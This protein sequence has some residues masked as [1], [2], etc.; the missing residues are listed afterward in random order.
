MKIL[1]LCDRDL[2]DGSGVS[3]KISMQSNEWVSKGHDVQLLSLMSLS[4]FSLNG[5]RLTDRQIDYKKGKFEVLLRLYKGSIRLKDILKDIDFDL[6]YMRFQLYD[7]FF[8]SALKNRPLIVELNSVD[9]EEVKLRSKGATLYNYMFRNLFLKNT[10]GCVCISREIQAKSLTINKPS[11]VIANG[12]NVQSFSYNSKEVLTKPSLVFIGSPGQAWHGLDKILILAKH[13]NNYDFHIIGKSAENIDNIFYHGYLSK[14]DAMQIIEKNT[15]GICSLALHRNSMEEASP[16]KSRQYLAQGLPII[17]A[18]ED[19]D[20][21]GEYPFMLRLPNTEDNIHK[22][23]EPIKAFIDSIYK[24]ENS[25]MTARQFA[26]DNLD[27][28]K[29]ED[30]RLLFMESILQ[31]K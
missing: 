10:D 27:A 17:Y 23:V 19:T 28:S 18:Y 31:D 1:Y 9:T 14:E 12:V 20:I 26:L 2:D 30:Q 4:F 29:K 6:V 7:P 5:E 22:N 21:E 3:Q 25:R 13:L 24:D 8:K 11:I 16:L 15:V